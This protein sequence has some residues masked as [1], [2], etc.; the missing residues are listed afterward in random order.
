MKKNWLVPCLQCLY[1]AYSSLMIIDSVKSRFVEDSKVAK[2]IS[3]KLSNA[4]LFF[5][6]PNGHENLDRDFLPIGARDGDMVI[7]HIVESLFSSAILRWAA[8][9]SQGKFLKK[10]K[11]TGEMGELRAHFFKV[12][13]KLIAHYEAK[14][15]KYFGFFTPMPY[16]RPIT[17][18]EFSDLCRLVEFSIGL[19]WGLELDKDISGRWWSHIMSALEVDDMISALEADK[20]N[21]VLEADDFIS[22]LEAD[23]RFSA[24]DV[25]KVISALRSCENDRERSMLRSMV[26]R[27][28]YRHAVDGDNVE[29]LSEKSSR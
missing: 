21:S 15:P 16:N 8:A 6:H 7:H 27:P 24:R 18:K 13:N 1:A 2:D 23:D 5:I 3:E 14:N 29:L 11:F 9:C 19:A 4:R 12:R 20:V 10:E 22:A 28:F 17:G 25:D 26:L